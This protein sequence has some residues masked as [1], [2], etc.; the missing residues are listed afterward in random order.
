MSLG[1]LDNDCD[2]VTN[3]A[4]KYEKLFASKSGRPRL[5]DTKQMIENEM[6]SENNNK[7]TVTVDE[8]TTRI[9]ALKIHKADG[10]RGTD[11]NYFI[12]ASHKFKI[13][14]CSLAKP[15]I[16]DRQTI[17]K[18]NRITFVS[19]WWHAVYFRA[20]SRLECSLRAT[21]LFCNDVLIGWVQKLKSARGWF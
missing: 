9:S 5:S 3:L 7:F 10:K 6:V 19:H 1:G 13:S 14:P 18:L 12:Y 8:V 16:Y 20:D 2:I 11:S 4:K 17:A 15:R 21:A